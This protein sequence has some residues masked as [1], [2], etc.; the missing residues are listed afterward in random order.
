MPLFVVPGPPSLAG[1]HEHRAAQVAVA[2]H[3]AGAAETR[4]IELHLKPLHQDQ[5]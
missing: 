4:G 5:T 1:E 2:D 3:G